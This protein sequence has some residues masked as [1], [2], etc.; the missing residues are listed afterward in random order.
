MLLFPITQIR[1]VSLQGY[2]CGDANSIDIS[3]QPK[4][5]SLALLSPEI[6]LSTTD[7]G[8]LMLRG[9]KVV[10][11]INHGFDVTASVVALDGS[12]AIIG[13][14]DGKLHIYSITGDIFVGE[15]VLEKHQG[16]VSFIRYSPLVSM[17]ASGNLNREAIVQHCVSREVFGINSQML[18]ILAE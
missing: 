5:L 10:S 16:A 9:A 6:A 8:V 1:R 15:A 12:E 3:S 17:F 4:D 11:T 7:S 18:F 2:Q 13:G 14:P